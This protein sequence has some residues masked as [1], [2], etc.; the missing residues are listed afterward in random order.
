MSAPTRTTYTCQR[1]GRPI[2]ARQVHVKTLSHIESEHVT[3]TGG[4]TVTVKAAE[5]LGVTHLAP[6]SAD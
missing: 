4:L 3:R 6:C 5:V 2:D 1:C